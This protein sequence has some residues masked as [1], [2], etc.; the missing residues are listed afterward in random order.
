MEFLESYNKTDLS[1]MEQT[2]YK[3]IMKDKHLYI[4][5]K[6]VN[7]QSRATKKWY[8]VRYIKVKDIEKYLSENTVKKKD[9]E[10]NDKKY[11]KVL[12]K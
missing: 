4:P 11:K 7:A 10:L 6:I 9:S 5:V 1:I 8:T 3:R 12:K 2:P